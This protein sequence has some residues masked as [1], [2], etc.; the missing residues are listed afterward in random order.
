[1]TTL[2]LFFS[3]FVPK[4]DERK[5]NTANRAWHIQADSDNQTSIGVKS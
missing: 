2:S 1:M 5:N 4:I 3:N